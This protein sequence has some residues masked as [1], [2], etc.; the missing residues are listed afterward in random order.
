VTEAQ[1]IARATRAQAALDE[2]VLPMVAELKREYT[3]RLIDVATTE[4]AP[5][6]RS[7]MIATLSVALKVVGTL[8]AGMT[9]IVRDGELVMQ[10]QARADRIS[11]MSDTAQRLLKIGAGY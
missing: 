3:A 1:R 4:L 2:F 11:Q 5:Q 8:E 9:E 10:S 6:R 7:D